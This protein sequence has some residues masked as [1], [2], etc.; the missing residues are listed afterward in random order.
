LPWRC[1]KKLEH[2]NHA[3]TRTHRKEKIAARSRLGA[4]PWLGEASFAD[5][6]TSEFICFC[7]YTIRRLID[8]FD[9]NQVCL[10][11]AG[12]GLNALIS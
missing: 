11:L 1:R 6:L 4:F 8:D 2:R 7:L 5:K 10:P 3:V 9:R 12:G